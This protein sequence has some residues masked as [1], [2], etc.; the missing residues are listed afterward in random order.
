MILRS[1]FLI[2]L[3]AIS[4]CSSSRS[5]YVLSPAGPAPTGGGI[6][7]GVG[8]VTMADYLM[9]RPYLVFQ[10]SPNKMELSDEHV[11]G[12]DLRN[13]F[14]RVL[15]SNIGRRKNTGNTRT[16][17]WDRE[18]DLKYQITV[19][20]RQ[21]HGTADGEAVLEASWRAYALPDSRLIAS[22]TSTLREPLLKDGYEE[23]TATQSRLID[24]LAA[25]IS[26]KL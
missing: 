23:L 14:T 4:S 13:D 16:Y 20:V 7:I 5:Y 19:D 6:G 25:E 15:A 21:F 12:G 8:P 10:S 1:L 18:K 26:S 2:S 24:K 11:W 17:P 9:E 22:K 3:F